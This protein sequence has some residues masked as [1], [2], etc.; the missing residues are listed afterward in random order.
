MFANEPLAGSLPVIQVIGGI[1]LS[2]LKHQQT[3]D[4]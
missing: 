4:D 3:H 2:K 1:V